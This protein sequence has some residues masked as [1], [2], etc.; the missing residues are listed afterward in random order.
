MVADEVETRGR[1][2]R[3]EPFQESHRLEH[4]VCGAISPAVLQAIAELAI[5]ELRQPLG[6]E[7]GASQIAGE[8]LKALAIA[9][10]NRDVCVKAQSGRARAARR[11]HVLGRRERLGLDPISE[12]QEALAGAGPGGNA[13][14]ERGGGQGREQGIFVSEGVGLPRIRVGAKPACLEEPCEALRH[15]D[16][17][18]SHLFVVGRRQG[19]EAGRSGVPPRGGC[20]TRRTS[21]TRR[22]R[23]EL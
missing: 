16:D 4:D 6:G 20:R 11:R 19:T 17:D 14:L 22:A 12:A 5:L 7:R 2:A 21:L 15:G 3:G 9:G 8:T 1:D 18:A 13:A 10:G 23:C